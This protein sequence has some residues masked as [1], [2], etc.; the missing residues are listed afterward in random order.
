MPALVKSNVGS[1]RG[2]TEDDLTKTLNIRHLH[3]EPVGKYLH[4]EFMPLLLK[5][6]NEGLA[7]AQGVP[8]VILTHIGYGA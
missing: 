7:N 2:T 8:L 5:K 1:E 6:F 3:I 4:T